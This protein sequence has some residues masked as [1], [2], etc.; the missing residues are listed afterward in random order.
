[1]TSAP[2]AS[3]S[4]L[5]SLLRATTT[6]LATFAAAAP[7]AA[8][9]DLL[10]FTRAESQRQ[11]TF[12]A[13]GIAWSCGGELCSGSGPD[14]VALWPGLCAAFVKAAGPVAAFGSVKDRFDAA[15]L[16]RCNESAVVAAPAA[17]PVPAAPARAPQA[18]PPPVPA[19]PPAPAA[20]AEIAT[21]VQTVSSTPAAAQPSSGP[22]LCNGLDDDGD[23]LVDEA[24]RVRVWSDR[25]RDLYGDPQSAREVCPHELAPGLV[26]NDY[27]CDDADSKKNPA[28]DNC[29]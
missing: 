16:T 27:D 21:Q 4:L 24:V 12:E 1:M 15:Q 23:G 20:A 5:R 28:R 26:L 10:A 6:L 29:G 8:A 7:V 2:L 22:E 3:K 9:T 25:D 19:P 18:A 11:G 13:G 17:P 14:D